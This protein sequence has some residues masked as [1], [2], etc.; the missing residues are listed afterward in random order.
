[1]TNILKWAA[2]VAASLLL[3]TSC[4]LIGGS[5]GA[6]QALSQMLRDGVINQ[7]QY[8]A[9]S[10]ALVGGDWDELKR[11]LIAV[12]SSWIGVPFITNLQRGKITARRG[13]AP[14]AKV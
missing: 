14:P 10:S 2:L 3:L 7:Q 4:S 13:T 8:D 11:W 6:H 1:M 5:A 12:G 9:L